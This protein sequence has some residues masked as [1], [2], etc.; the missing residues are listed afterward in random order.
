VKEDS[1]HLL[2]SSLFHWHMAMVM[3][4]LPPINILHRIMTEGSVTRSGQ[5]GST[6][7]CPDMHPDLRRVQKAFN[8]LDLAQKII[9]VTKHMPVPLKEDGT[10]QYKKWGD[11][12]KSQ[13]LQEPMTTFKSKY[14]GC[15]RSVK[16]H[17]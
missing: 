7:L 16:R 13:Y 15:L 14:R 12:E 10:P 11:R 8:G 6:I 2:L 1:V 3:D 17:L 4:G 9:V 5:P